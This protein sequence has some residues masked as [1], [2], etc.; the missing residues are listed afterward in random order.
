MWKEDEFWGFNIIVSS[1]VIFNDY[2]I[3]VVVMYIKI[4]IYRYKL[5]DIKFFWVIDF[6]I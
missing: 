5:I 2:N 1:W 4:I 6:F 3:R